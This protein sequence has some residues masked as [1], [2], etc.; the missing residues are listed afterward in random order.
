MSLIYL[1][2]RT[3][4]FWAIALAIAVFPAILHF[5]RRGKKTFFVLWGGFAGGLILLAITWI[6]MRG[7]LH[8]EAWVRTWLE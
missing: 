4:P 1:A 2:A 6:V 7:D 8:S 5:R 3:F